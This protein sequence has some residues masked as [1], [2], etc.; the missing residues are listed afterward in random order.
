[1]ADLVYAKRGLVA[2]L[3]PQA[4]TTVEP[5]FAILLP[6]G[7]A[8]LTTRLVSARDSVEERLMD[9]THQIDASLNHFANAPIQ[10]AAFACTGASYVAGRERETEICDRLELSRGYEIVTAARAVTASLQAL[11]A[12][13]IGLVSPYSETLTKASVA[14]WQSA[15]FDVAQVAT[16]TNEAADFHAI[17]SLN[18]DG[19]LAALRTLEDKPLDAIVLLGTG[20][21]TL[22]T[23]L[24]VANWNGPPVTSSMLSLAWRVVLSIDVVAPDRDNMLAWTKGD[25]WRDRMAVLR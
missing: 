10:A 11:G 22:R 14:Y 7:I 16:V 23:I 24:D 19:S 12:K 4:N 21:P 3:T 9:Y 1:M 5:E 8:M 20:M 6:P 2:V 25:E 15:G 17:Y 13:T 18:T